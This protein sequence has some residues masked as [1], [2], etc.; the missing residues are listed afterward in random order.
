MIYSLVMIV[1]RNAQYFFRLVLSDDIFIE[2]FLDFS[3]SFKGHG[4][5]GF[6]I[7][8]LYHIVAY[9]NTLVANKSLVSAFD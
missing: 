8:L 3:G 1:Y 6:F 4:L 2:L 9:G 5:I 7:G